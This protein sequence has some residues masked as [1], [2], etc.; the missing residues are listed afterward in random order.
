MLSGLVL[1]SLFFLCSGSDL[2][3]NPSPEEGDH[4]VGGNDV[5]T[6]SGVHWSQCPFG[7]QCCIVDSASDL[8]VAWLSCDKGMLRDFPKDLG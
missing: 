8:L 5:I 2:L 6:C 7:R 1:F 3:R 4:Q